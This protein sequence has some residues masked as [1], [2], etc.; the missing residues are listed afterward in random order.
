MGVGVMLY[1]LLIEYLKAK[2]AACRDKHGRTLLQQACYLLGLG[3]SRGYHV[4]KKS[5]HRS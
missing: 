3:W 4:A 2:Q 5:L 1:A